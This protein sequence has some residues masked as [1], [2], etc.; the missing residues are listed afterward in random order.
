[1]QEPLFNKRNAIVQY[2]RKPVMSRNGKTVLDPGEKV[3]VLVASTNVRDPKRVLIG[4]SLK[5]RLD[6]F[7]WVDGMHKPHHGRTTAVIRAERWA[8]RDIEDVPVPDSIED[9]IKDFIIRCVKYYKGTQLPAWA[10]KLWPEWKDQLLMNNFI[11]MEDKGVN[12][13]S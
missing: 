4:F 13:V 5:H 6:K 11:E 7:D 9:E 2:I 1:M 8:N 3:G 12:P 10:R